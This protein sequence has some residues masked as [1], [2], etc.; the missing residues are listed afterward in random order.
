MCIF[1]FRSPFLLISLFSVQLLHLA[2]FAGNLSS[3]LSEREPNTLC[4]AVF[5]SFS[6]RPR[7]HFPL[8]CLS[9]S[10]IL[11]SLPSLPFCIPRHDEDVFSCCPLQ[12]IV[13]EE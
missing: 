1:R 7:V 11:I 13:D 4:T 3:S 10:M 9:K 12:K 2:V 6:S 5:S 8:I